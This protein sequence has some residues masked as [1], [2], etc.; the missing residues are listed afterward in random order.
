[1]SDVAP[2]ECMD[3]VVLDGFLTALAIG[4]ELVRPEVWLPKGLSRQKVAVSF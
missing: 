4:P 3:I 2:D 1:M